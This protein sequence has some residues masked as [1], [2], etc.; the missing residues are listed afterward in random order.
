MVKFAW[1]PILNSLNEEKTGIGDALSGRGKKQKKEMQNITLL[2]AN[3]YYKESTEL[4]EK[5]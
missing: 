2:T 4:K 3:V 1:K 5:E